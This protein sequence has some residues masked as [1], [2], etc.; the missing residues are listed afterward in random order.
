MSDVRGLH[1]ADFQKAGGAV[2]DAAQHGTLAKFMTKKV[3]E[4][5]AHDGGT[6]SR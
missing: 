3:Y 1:R 6:V 5:G 2:L 4:L